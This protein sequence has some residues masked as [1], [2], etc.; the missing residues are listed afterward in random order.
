MPTYIT[1][2]PWI[3]LYSFMSNLI[4]NRL[5]RP[6]KQEYLEYLN[7]LDSGKFSVADKMPRKTKRK[8]KLSVNQ[9]PIFAVIRV[10]VGNLEPLDLVRSSS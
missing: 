4:L 8:Q 1:T 5:L 10:G 2:P 7:L 3:A 9:L 6:Y